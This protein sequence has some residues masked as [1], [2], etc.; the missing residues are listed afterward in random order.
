LYDAFIT[1]INATG[2]ALA[3]STYL[4]GSSDDDSWA[5]AVAASGNAYLTGNTSSTD[6]PTESPIQ[7][8]NAGSSD[9]FV[10]KINAT[11]SAL[12]YS[13]YLG[14][15]DWDCSYGIAV[16]TSGN[17]YLTGESRSTDF[18]TESPIQGTHAG[19][20][21]DAFITKI[22]ATGSALVYSTY[23]GGASSGEHGRGIAVDTP[24]NAYL[25][26]MTISTEFPTESPI[27]GTHGGGW[28]AFITKINAT[29]SALVYS[30]YWG[31]SNDEWGLGTAVDGS[32]NAYV[33][34]WTSSTDFPTESSIQGTHG[35]GW[36]AFVTKI[37]GICTLDL[38]LS[39]TAETLTMD[40]LLGTT[41]PA[42]WNIWVSFLNQ[43]IRLGC[44][45]IPV[46]YPPISCPIP[47]PG[48]PSLGTIGVLTTLTTA[49]DGI[50]CSDWETVDTGSVV[51]ATTAPTPK[52][53]K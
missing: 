27:Q 16:D 23:L 31:G 19:G 47:F 45:P 2:S 40:F 7:G 53:M 38:N 11:G 9:A 22:N 21:Y 35:G 30:T 17:A 1:K 4:G 10:T 36:D 15:S 49:E 20:L 13:T 5:I 34:G 39:Y 14:G 43:T 24:G 41:Q 8:T 37:G 18:P 28:D 26:G 3:Y 6:F 29:G 12:A 33:I 52:E 32:G 44:I 50:I 48:F 51:T 25:T 42:N 46:I